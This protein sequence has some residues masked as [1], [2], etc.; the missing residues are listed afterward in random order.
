MLVFRSLS[1]VLN[2][3]CEIDV[4]CHFIPVISMQRSL[5]IDRVRL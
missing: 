4:F 3:S 2:R 5:S 1:F